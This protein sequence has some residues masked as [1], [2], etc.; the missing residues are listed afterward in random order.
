MSFA[1]YFLFNTT[2]TSVIYTLSLH[3][4]LPIYSSLGDYDFVANTSGD[5][6]GASSVRAFLNPASSSQRLI[7]LKENVIKRWLEER[8]EEHTS[9]LQSR[10]DVV[11]RLLLEKK[12]RESAQ[13]Q[14]I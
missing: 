5:G 7:S 4:A 9:E 3:D 12:K 11:C 13:P 6:P 2:A 14:T 1:I 8:S 10:R